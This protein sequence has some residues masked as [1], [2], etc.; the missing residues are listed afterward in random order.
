MLTQVEFCR[1]QDGAEFL[2]KLGQRGIVEFV[3]ED[4]IRHNHVGATL[5]QFDRWRRLHPDT[6]A[7]VLSLYS[8]GRQFAPRLTVVPR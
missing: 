8:N 6:L 3:G 4:A 5:A 2:F 7:E 1:F